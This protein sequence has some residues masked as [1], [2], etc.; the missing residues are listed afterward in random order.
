MR[1][2]VRYGHA[3]KPHSVD[4]ACRSDFVENHEGVGGPIYH[5]GGQSLLR[6]PE[7]GGCRFV[8]SRRKRKVAIGVAACWQA[9]QRH[10]QPRASILVGSLVGMVICPRPSVDG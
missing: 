5:G 4:L 10:E 2:S 9:A 8:V 6:Q 7:M 1:G 3:V